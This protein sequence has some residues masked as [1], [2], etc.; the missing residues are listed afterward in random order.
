[1]FCG[2][3]LTHDESVQSAVAQRS[4]SDGGDKTEPQRLTDSVVHPEDANEISGG[5]TNAHKHSFQERRP[6]TNSHEHINK[7]NST[8][9]DTA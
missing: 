8:E 2:I 1:M 5:R 7:R 6:Y 9:R 4:E 3:L